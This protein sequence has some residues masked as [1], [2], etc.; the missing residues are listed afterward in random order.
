MVPVFIDA[1]AVHRHMAL[2]AVP[3]TCTYYD[4]K[5]SLSIS[6]W[7]PG[8]QLF[9]ESNAEALREDQ[10][11]RP[12]EGSLFRVLPLHAEPDYVR[13]L[14]DSMENLD[15]AWDVQERGFPP[16]P[17]GRGRLLI[18]GPDHS[19]VTGPTVNLTFPQIVRQ[20]ASTLSVESSDLA[21]Y[22]PNE[23]IESLAFKGMPVDGVMAVDFRDNIGYRSG[24]CGLFIDSR[25]LGVDVTFLRFGTTVLSC[26]DILDALDTDV[27]SGYRAEVEGYESVAGQHGTYVFKHGAVV[28]VWMEFDV[29]ASSGDES[30]DDQ[31]P[32]DPDDLEDEANTDGEDAPEHLDEEHRLQHESAT[33]EVAAPDDGRDRSRT[34]RRLHTCEL[35]PHS[36][37]VPDFLLIELENP[38]KTTAHKQTVS[39]LELLDDT[40]DQPTAF[41]HIDVTTT[42]ELA[43][44]SG[45]SVHIAHVLEA[46]EGTKARQNFPHGCISQCRA[47][48]TPCRTAVHKLP[49]LDGMEEQN[50]SISGDDGPCTLRLAEHVGPVHHDISMNCLCVIDREDLAAIWI[51]VQPWKSLS[52]GPGPH[53]EQLHEST[54]QHRWPA[55]PPIIEIYTDGSA[56]HGAAGFSV[57]IVGQWPEACQ[58]TFLGCFGGPVTTDAEDFHYVK[59]EF[60]DA[61]NAEVTALFW[62]IMWCLGHWNM[63]QRPWVTFRYDAQVAGSFASGRWETNQQGIGEFAREAARLL[64]QCIGAYNIKWEHTKAHCGQP[65]NEMADSVAETCRMGQHCGI[66]EPD[67]GWPFLIGGICLKWAALVPM[68]CATMAFPLNM[69]GQ[70]CWMEDEAPPQPLAVQQ[71]IPTRGD[72]S[73]QQFRLC[74]TAASANVQSCIGKYKF[75]EQQLVDRGVDVFCVQE[76]RSREG[77]IKSADFI[78][79]ASDGKGHWGAEV[80]VS[81]HATLAALDGHNI[82]IDETCMFVRSSSP[83]HLHLEIDAAGHKIHVASVHYPQRNRGEEEKLQYDQV[84]NDIMAAASNHTCIV[85]VDANGRVPLAFNAVTGSLFEDEEDD[86]GRR[87]VQLASRHGMWFPSTFDCCQQGPGKTWTQA[88]GGRSRIDYFVINDEIPR[89][90]VATKVLDDFDLLTPNDDH[91]PIQI[92]LDFNF[93]RRGSNPAR[94]KR[95]TGLDIRKLREP[96]RLAAFEDALDRTGINQVPWDVDVNTH[97][98]WLQQAVQSAL[99]AALPKKCDVPRSPYIPERAWKIRERK[100]RLKR[101]TLARK[102]HYRGEVRELVF[103]LWNAKRESNPSQLRWALKKV[104]VLYELCAGAIQLA[105]A[106]M[107]CLIREKKN[108]M[109][110]GLAAKF[111]KTRPDEIM[112]QLKDLHLGRRRRAPWKKHLPCL[113]TDARVAN[114]RE[115]MDAIWLEH[116]GKMEFGSIVKAADFLGAR[117]SY[118]DADLEC[119]LEVAALPS[120]AEVEAAFRSTKCNKAPGLDQICGEVLKWAPSRM[121]AAAFPLMCKASAR[122][123]QPIQW[124]GGVLAESYKGKGALSDPSAYRSLYVSSMVGKAYHRII[125]QKATSLATDAFDASHFSAK[126]GA[127]VTAAS[128]LIAQF[129]R[130]QCHLN[131]SAAVVY[132]DIQSAYYSV[133]RQLAYGDG[134]VGCDDAQICA[135]L[136]HFD[137]PRD[138]WDDLIKAVQTGGIMGHHGTS[139]HV[140]S[141]VKDAHDRSFFVTRYADAQHVCVTEAGSRP[142]ESLADLIYAWI[143]HAVLQDIKTCLRK[144]GVLQKVPFTGDLSPFAGDPTEELEF[145]GPTWADDSS[146]ACADRD[147][148]HLV[149]KT[150]LLIQAIVDQCAVRGLIPNCKPGKTS[151]VMSLRGKGSRKEKLNLFG[152]GDRHLS[153]HTRRFGQLLI[154]VVPTYVHL[155]CAVERGMTMETEAHRRGA[156]ASTAFEPLRRLIFQNTSIPPKTRGQL[157][158]VF[159]DSTYFNLEIWRGP[160]DK[161]WKRLVLGHQQLTKRLLAK[162][163]PAEEIHQITPAEVTCLTS[164]PPLWL[165]HKSKRLR[166]LISLINAAPPVLWA[167]VQAERTWGEKLLQDLA[168]MKSL[169]TSS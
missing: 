41:D 79:F 74:F 5:E 144:M 70:I 42:L 18:L 147:P 128:F 117:A 116:F 51:L 78:R 151:V 93:V 80:W 7:P 156:I 71:V 111:G 108:Q 2:I 99:C 92:S 26:E 88:A 91:D 4:L 20:V 43:D 146:F 83:R 3:K 53:W 23:T 166:F 113:A 112:G 63:L 24:G 137:L 85:G 154:P 139:S 138:V 45:L 86:T 49:Q 106:S 69:H 143:F 65:W 97:A 98:L 19:F 64:E 27:P 14:A 50:P 124:R 82:A 155:G 121:A 133:V 22:V 16:E 131:Q 8:T 58:T 34:P 140:R 10:S 168:W 132:L 13:D 167:L 153:V 38:A 152:N 134:S 75:L 101:L 33:P 52:L 36:V 66:P 150:E 109:L 148:A 165:I 30:C 141:L 56:K 35:C 1:E 129:E 157:F 110:Q 21:F 163:F 160:E 40:S 72:F 118:T 122:R 28:T 158:T 130:W 9:Y 87:L 162:D 100:Q 127:P 12:T 105:T 136:K 159:I 142:G 95:G 57:V 46:V 126:K 164:H 102:T 123:V 37:T 81:R 15:W 68:S 76:A 48:N 31:P 114:S 47:I 84:V 145:L 115:A 107:Q 89:H 25:D 59:A 135:V 161:G 119:E 32:E 55:C 90:A 104:T 60:P 103:R 61:F 169:V 29:M 17:G 6:L 77:C 11:I 125:R 44:R 94:L 120:F 39:C 96:E 54:K 73:G 62:A 67:P 149:H